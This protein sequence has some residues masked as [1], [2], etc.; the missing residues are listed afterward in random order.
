VFLKEAT[1]FFSID[2]LILYPYF[3]P[4]PFVRKF[5]IKFFLKI[6]SVVEVVDLLQKA[7]HHNLRGGNPCSKL[8]KL[9][10]L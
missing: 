3:I 2:L 9:F 8:N 7:P 6:K 4:H 10:N 1:P 5:F